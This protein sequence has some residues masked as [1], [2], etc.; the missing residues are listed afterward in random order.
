[1]TKK[2]WLL[3]IFL[4]ALAAVYVIWFTDWFKPKTFHVSHTIRQMHFRRRGAINTEPAL[5]FGVEPPQE[6]T[7][8][9]IVSLADFEKDPETLPI[10]HLISDS[11]S[12]PTRD[13][14]YGQRVRGLR[15]SI[16]GAEAG[17]L[18]TNM[19]YRIFIK[20]GR[21]RGQQDFEI[22]GAPSTN[23]VAGTP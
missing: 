10:W 1:M 4:I 23:A 2:N 11:N 8:I 12:P 19:V 14:V 9:K 20:A 22:G 6:V 18:Q 16:A 21:A 3:V 5:I 7:E 15:P 17:E 13:F